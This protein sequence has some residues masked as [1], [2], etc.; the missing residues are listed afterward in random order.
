MKAEAAQKAGQPPALVIMSANFT[1]DLALKTKSCRWTNCS[2][3]ATKSRYVLTNEFW[4]A[5]HKNAQVMGVTYAIPFHNSTP[6]LYYN[7]TMFDKAGITQAPQT[8]QAL[9]EDAKS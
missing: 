3:S 1:T 2:N 8:W 4:P 6:I 9:L 5:M 7:K